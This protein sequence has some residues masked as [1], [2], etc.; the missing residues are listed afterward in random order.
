MLESLMAIAWWWIGKSKDEGSPW[1]KGQRGRGLLDCNVSKAKYRNCVLRNRDSSLTGVYSKR[2]NERNTR[3]YGGAHL[4]HYSSPISTTVQTGNVSFEHTIPHSPA[5]PQVPF[6]LCWGARESL[7][8]CEGYCARGWAAG[9][10]LGWVGGEGAGGCPEPPARGNGAS[11][12][13]GSLPGSLPPAQTL[14]DPKTP[15][16][17]PAITPLRKSCCEQLLVGEAAT[18]AP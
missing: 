16:Q 7:R 9:K 11:Q 2:P 1:E 5:H 4:V 6:L 3:G 12:L 13:L 17:A 10:R 18:S 8:A 15:L 14:C